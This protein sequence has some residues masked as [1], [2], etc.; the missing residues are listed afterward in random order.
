MKKSSEI[1]SLP[2]FSIMD[3]KEVG[4]VRS[5]LINA[6]KG[7]V[8]YLIV[9]TLSLEFG[10]KAIPFEKIEGIGDYAVTI[11]SDASIV[12]LSDTPSAHDMLK[13]NVQIVNNKVMTKKGSLLGNVS[14]YY[15][16][17]LSGKILGCVL[18]NNNE[19]DGQVILEESILTFGKEVVVV[20]ENIA[21]QLV[22]FDDFVKAVSAGKKSSG[23]AVEPVKVAEVKPVVA[24]EAPQ[25]APEKKPE[26]ISEANVYEAVVTPK[27]ADVPMAEP[28]AVAAEP[29]AEPKV[30]SKAE[31]ND[32][33]ADVA[34]QFEDRQALFLKGKRVTRDFLGED[35]KVL[36]QAGTILTEEQVLEVKA[37][38]RNKLLELSMSVSD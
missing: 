1:K 20:V 6:E 8:E 7:I 26:P 32:S 35:G 14:E 19:V 22:S 21:E 31:S 24:P 33:T 38:G 37:L 16:D 27:V 34:K 13:K 30:E 25:K 12:E 15:I 10:I 2:I 29:K 36:I 17:E 9:E 23:A 3:G 18:T 4:N 11:E 5:L 28:K